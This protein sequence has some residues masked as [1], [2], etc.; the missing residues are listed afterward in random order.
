M[1]TAP[2]Q[3][4]THNVSWEIDLEADTPRQAAQEA[5]NDYFRRG[6]PGPDDACVFTI[7]HQ[8]DAGRVIS[9]TIDLAED[10]DDQSRPLVQNE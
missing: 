2:S 10:T 5:W 7:T 4:T 3:T 8:D 6:E 9:Q 1:N